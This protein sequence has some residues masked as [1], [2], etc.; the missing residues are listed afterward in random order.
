G[1]PYARLV[2]LT[3]HDQN[4]LNEVDHDSVSIATLRGISPVWLWL[5][6]ESPG[7]TGPPLRWSHHTGRIGRWLL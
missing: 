2:G 5:V 4:P 3:R 1:V 6:A 7:Y